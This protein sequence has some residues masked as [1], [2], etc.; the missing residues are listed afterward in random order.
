MPYSKQRGDHTCKS[1]NRLKPEVESVDKSNACFI[2]L[3]THY[4]SAK[5]KFRPNLKNELFV[6]YK[7]DKDVIVR[8]HRVY[9]NNSKAPSSQQ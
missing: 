4:S 6:W 3:V 9:T 8:V 7:M 5:M 2:N 1:Q